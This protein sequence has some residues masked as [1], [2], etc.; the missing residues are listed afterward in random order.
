[1][2]PSD[3]PPDSSPQGSRPAPNTYARINPPP[4]IVPP[5]INR[6]KLWGC[7]IAP[8]AIIALTNLLGG[9]MG[10]LGL[11]PFFGFIAFIVCG[12]GFADT[13]QQRYRGPSLTMLMVFYFFGEL[14][15]C[16]A[17]WFGTCMAVMNFGKF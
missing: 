11:S 2:D 15:V 14:V 10:V 4:V 8:P 17:T 3:S 16:L 6:N 9:D 13:L 5:Q 7:L 1:M 12:M